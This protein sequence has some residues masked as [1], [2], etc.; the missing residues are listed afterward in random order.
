MFDRVR[1]SETSC[2]FLVAAG[3][4]WRCLESTVES[5]SECQP[6][7]DCVHELR[8]RM[9][10][11]THIG[12]WLRTWPLLSGQPDTAIIASIPYNSR[13]VC[14]CPLYC[15]TPT[16]I[17]IT[18]RRQVQIL[19]IPPS[20]SRTLLRHCN[21]LKVRVTKTALAMYTTH[22]GPLPLTRNTCDTCICLKTCKLY[23]HISSL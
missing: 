22:N 5:I 12:V 6:T 8:E 14:H 16:S 18:L 7:R 3:V 20:V 21:Y 11:N 23:I 2:L 17:I 15:S 13:Q 4:R 10:F 19:Q 1:A 9:N